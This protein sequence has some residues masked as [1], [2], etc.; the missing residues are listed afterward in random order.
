MAT[1]T[2]IFEER[3]DFDAASQTDPNQT[4]DFTTSQGPVAYCIYEKLLF[5]YNTLEQ[6]YVELKEKFEGLQEE[7]KTAILKN[8]ELGKQ[9]LDLEV[10]NDELEESLCG[11]TAALRDRNAKLLA[12]ERCIINMAMQLHGGGNDAK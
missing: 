2:A 5:D 6:Q 9:N 10:I 1:K 11:I 4:N 12:A 7:A 8:D 3:S